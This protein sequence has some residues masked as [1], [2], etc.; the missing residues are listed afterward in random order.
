MAP[1]VDGPRFGVPLYTV[2]EAARFVAV[3]TS[4]FA[5]W[6]KGYDRRSEIRKSV[7]GEPIVTALAAPPRAT[8]RSRLVD[9]P[10]AWCWQ[11]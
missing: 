1:P 11:A 9:S 5:S 8:P 7:H 2:G 3:P 4:T 10:R 6:A